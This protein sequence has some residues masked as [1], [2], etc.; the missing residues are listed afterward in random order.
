MDS[1]PTSLDAKAVS[2]WKHLARLCPSFNYEQ[3]FKSRIIFSNPFPRA[4]IQGRWLDIYK[5]YTVQG[6]CQQFPTHTEGFAGS[7]L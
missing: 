3:I 1:G 7:K 6:D 2:S 4:R 5:E